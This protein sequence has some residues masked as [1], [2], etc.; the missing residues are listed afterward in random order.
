MGPLFSDVDSP[1]NDNQRPMPNLP[2]PSQAW[3]C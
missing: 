2:T 1:R 3:A